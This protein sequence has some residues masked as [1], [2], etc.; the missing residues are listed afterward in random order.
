MTLVIIFPLLT[1]IYLEFSPR[2]LQNPP[3]WGNTI[4]SVQWHLWPSW[5]LKTKHTAHGALYHNSLQYLQWQ[6]AETWQSHRLLEFYNTNHYGIYANTH[7]YTHTH[8]LHPT[9]IW[10]HMAMLMTKKNPSLTFPCLLHSPSKILV[11]PFHAVTHLPSSDGTPIPGS[12]SLGKVSS[13]RK[14]QK[15]RDIPASKLPYGS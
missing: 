14:I 7:I 1:F 10:F 15:Q 5:M 9:C 11:T 13:H 12:P 8:L 4:L 3:P 6:L 2:M